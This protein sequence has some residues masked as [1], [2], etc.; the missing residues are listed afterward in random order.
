MNSLLIVPVG[1]VVLAGSG[2]DD[3]STSLHLLPR[4]PERM[5]LTY[6][7]CPMKGAG[8]YRWKIFHLAVGMR[9]YDH[10]EL[11]LV[12]V[13][14]HTFNHQKVRLVIYPSLQS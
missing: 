11:K 5:L 10:V 8:E 4:V 7:R 12:L 13:I 3:L 2:H 1:G 6:D 14:G 9:P